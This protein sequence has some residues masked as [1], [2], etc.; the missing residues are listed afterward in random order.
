[1]KTILSLLI[2]LSFLPFVSTARMGRPLTEKPIVIPNSQLKDS[3]FK[4]PVINP[5]SETWDLSWLHVAGKHLERQ[6]IHAVN[7]TPAQ[8]KDIEAIG[9][10]L[11]VVPAVSASLQ[12]KGLSSVEAKSSNSALIAAITQSAKE[13][14]EPETQANVVAFARALALDPVANEKKLKK[15]R[16]N[17]RL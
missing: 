14:W 16:D 8:T 12:S 5:K 4:A 6:A 9:H 17:C 15:V 1:M 3:A 13:N 7:N 10:I 11:K 2:S